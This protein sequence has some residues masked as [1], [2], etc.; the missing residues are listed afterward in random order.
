MSRGS[1][2]WL[3]LEGGRRVIDAIS[4]WWVNLH[5]HARPEIAEAIYRQAS[6]L[7][8]VIFAGY[9]HDPAERLADVLVGALPVGLEKVFFSDNGS[10]AVEVA[11][12]MAVQA[13]HNRG[14][15]KTRI[16]AFEG[17][18]HGDTFGA[19]AAG[20]T[21]VFNAP[22][23]NMFFEVD[24]LPYPDTWVGDRD[25]AMKEEAALQNIRSYLNQYAD[26]VAMV[27]IEPLIQGAGGMRMVHSSFLRALERLCRDYGVLLGFDE[28]MT[29]FGRTGELFACIKA[30]IR[31]DIICLSKGITGGFLPLAVTVT[32]AEVFDAFHSI[33]PAKALYHGHSYTANPLGCAAALASWDILTK[34]QLFKTFETR[35]KP[36]INTLVKHEKVD[37]IRNCGTIFAFDVKSDQGGYFDGLGPRLKQ[38]FAA[39][40]V[41]LRPLGNTLYV[42]PPYVISNKELE[43]VFETIQEVIDLV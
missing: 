41:L 17:A 37:R 20:A 31:P 1:G 35:Y 21:S 2:V 14:Q 29:G 40:S 27:L 39:S 23:E 28:V 6:E 13:S 3:E 12:K 22:F 8:H 42:M 15:P 7:E 43:T 33:D 19:M 5:G 10:T 36:Y 11:I 26:E 32:T 25:A 4:S 34:D 24:R 9:S 18:Y 16:A 30:G 38:A